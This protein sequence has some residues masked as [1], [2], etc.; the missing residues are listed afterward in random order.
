MSSKINRRDFLNKSSIGILG[1]GILPLT[2]INF[3]NNPPKNIEQ[4]AKIKEYRL[5]GRT[6][7][8]VS[9]IGCGSVLVNTEGLFKA[10]ISAGVNLIDT[11]ESGWRNEEVMGRVINKIDRG[12]VFINT[13][14]MVS[15]TESADRVVQ[16]MKDFLKRAG[17]TYLDGMMLWNVNSIKETENKSFLEAF[18]KLRDEKLVRFS[19]ISCHGSNY[20]INPKDTMADIITA[21]IYSDR[22]D[23]VMFVHNYVQHEMGEDILNACAKKGVGTLLM[24]TDPFGGYFLRFIKQVNEAK[25]NNDSIPES[26]RIVYDKMIAKQNEAQPFLQ[27]YGYLKDESYKKAALS[28][29]LN[30]P[31]VHSALISFRNFEDVNEY[32]R[33]SGARLNNENIALID[34]L[35]HFFGFS[36][37]RHACG[38][39]EK[40]CPYNVPVNTIMRYNH[41]FMAHSM[42]EYAI[43][44]YRELPGSKADKCSVCE[45]RCEK[46]CPYNVVI[47]SLLSFAHNNLNS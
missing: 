31:L 25:L 4:S 26:V 42:K 37:C 13:K 39:C 9:D 1:T 38:K 17:L 29:V 12:S 22:Y 11:S 27:K 36:Y 19:G 14:I 16:R 23:L 24:K 2:D 8:R 33:L 30:D 28:F 35:V 18:N 41:Y 46:A 44:K 5:L 40:S 15:E 43:Q 20:I 10:I 7:F 3:S 45:G 32:A 47:Q 6:G 21:A 34:S